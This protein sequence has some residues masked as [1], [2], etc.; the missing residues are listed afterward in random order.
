MERG[1]AGEAAERSGVRMAVVVCSAAA[2]SPPPNS[3]HSAASN[4]DATYDL[5]LPRTPLQTARL[6]WQDQETV[7][8]TSLRPDSLHILIGSDGHSWERKGLTG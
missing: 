8:R 5:P 4:C 1:E 7:S 2:A 6:L 3:S